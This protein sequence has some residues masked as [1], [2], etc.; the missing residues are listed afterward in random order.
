MLRRCHCPK[1]AFESTPPRADRACEAASRFCTRTECES[2]IPNKTL[3]ISAARP[4]DPPSVTK[5][6]PCRSLPWREEVAAGGP[7]HDLP[8]PDAGW[9]RQL[10]AAACNGAEGTGRRPARPP[11]PQ[12][13]RPGGGQ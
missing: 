8:Y 7:S 9:R 6:P 3:T 4:A 11:D 2:V 10:G 13:I 5:L 12:P 1:A